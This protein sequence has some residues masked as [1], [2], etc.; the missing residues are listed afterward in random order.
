LVN[1]RT[2]AGLIGED[3]STSVQTTNPSYP[4]YAQHTAYP[5]HL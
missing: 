4:V 3:F 1:L 5:P 2:Q